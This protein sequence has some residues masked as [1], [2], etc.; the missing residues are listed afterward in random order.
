[1][2]V[3]EYVWRKPIPNKKN[4]KDAYTRQSDGVGKLNSNSRT[5]AVYVIVRAALVRCGRGCAMVGYFKS[6]AKWGGKSKLEK[7]FLV[8][9]IAMLHTHTQSPRE[10][11][12]VLDCNP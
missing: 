12:L 4:K 2:L 11:D 6:S 5:C 8:E 7:I 9:H 10:L 1:M 3:N